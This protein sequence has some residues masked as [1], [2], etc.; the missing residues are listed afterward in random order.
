MKESSN[1]INLISSGVVVKVKDAFLCV[2]IMENT[3]AKATFRLPNIYFYPF[4]TD[5]DMPCCKWMLLARFKIA[6]KII[7]RSTLSLS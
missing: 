4:P 3:Y 1:D 6:E 7:Y 5:V 2:I